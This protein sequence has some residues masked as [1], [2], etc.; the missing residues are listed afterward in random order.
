MPYYLLTGATGLLGRYL[1][2]DLLLAGQPLAVVVRSSRFAP[3]EHRVDAVMRHWEAELNRALPRPIVLEG[4]IAEPLLG[5]D[6]ATLAWVRSHCSS[7]IHNAASLT[8]QRTEDN[9]PYRSNVGGT[10]N[11]LDVCREAG[12]RSYHHVSTAYV[13]GQRTG[14]VYGHE[15]DVGQTLGND[16]EKSKVAA[17]QRV[18]EADFL[19]RPTILRPSIIVG[20]NETGYTTTYHG[21]YTPLQ[22]AYTLA[23]SSPA[24]AD[25]VDFLAGLQLAGHEGKNFVPVN[26][27]SAVMTHLITHAECHGQTYHVTHPQPVSVGQMH[28]AIS[29]RLE[30]RITRKAAEESLPASPEYEREYRKQMGIYQA[31]WRDDP[32][33]DARNTHAAAPHLP[34]PSLDQATLEKLIDFAIDANFGWPRPPAQGP[35]FDVRH[36]LEPLLKA[37]SPGTDGVGGSESELD[38]SLG[39]AVNGSGGGQWRLFVHDGALRGAELGISDRPS[40]VYYLNSQTYRELFERQFTVEQ[41]VGAGRLVIE[42]NNGRSDRELV[43]IF[44]QLVARP[45]ANRAAGTNGKV[46][47]S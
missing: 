13:C 28:Q 6:A 34:C 3:A 16:Y 46:A 29:V 39:L 47:C 4:D 2:R 36:T 26:W 30:R 38:H 9:E 20:D 32:Q 10:Q 37:G 12:I 5:F 31:Y 42:A 8:F 21:F 1:L 40:A 15:L 43:E 22:L 45:A 24:K 35:D 27:V 7:V 19:D 17:E 33:F 23:K 44:E 14:T 25:Q 18:R 11:M 41:A